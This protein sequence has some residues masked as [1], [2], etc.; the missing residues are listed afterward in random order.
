MQFDLSLAVQ[1]IQGIINGFIGLLPLILIALLV[2]GVF[3]FGARAVRSLVERVAQGA[4]LAPNAA[5]VFG[6]LAYYGVVIAGLLVALTIVLPTFQPAEL[7]G[8]LGIGSVAIGFAFRDILQNFL[9]GLLLLLTQP[10][11]IGDQIVVNNFEGTVEDIETRATK[12]RTYDGRLVVIPNATLFTDSVIVNTAFPKRR[13][14]YDV[15]IGYGDDVEAAREQILAA[16]RS[17]EDICEEPAPDVIVVELADSTVNL[18][19][20]WWT[21]SGRADVLRVQ[22]RVLT[23]IR[24]RLPEEGIDLPFPTSV[25]LFH[26]QTEETDGDRRRQREGWPAGRGDVPDPRPIASSL[27]EALSSNGQAR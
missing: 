13:S 12:I 11:K 17:V 7:V 20:R 19:A 18:R 22:D 10:F 1:T 2:F 6:R 26:D 14:Q 21:H 3:I 15:G 25:V 27:G 8:L 16:V 9:A 5:E 4:S 23:A 24:N